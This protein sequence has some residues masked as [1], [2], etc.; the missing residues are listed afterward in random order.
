MHGSTLSRN[1]C[2]SVS[3]LRFLYGAS[4]EEKKK[5]KKKKEEEDGM[6]GGPPKQRQ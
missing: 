4:A 5:K 3:V 6:L 2:V 1:P